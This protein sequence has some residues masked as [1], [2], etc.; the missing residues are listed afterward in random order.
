MFGVCLPL[1]GKILPRH[2][3]EIVVE[4]PSHVGTPPITAA[5]VE[6]AGRRASEGAGAYNICDLPAFH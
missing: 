6:E 2:I 3:L 4:K 1:T 5:V